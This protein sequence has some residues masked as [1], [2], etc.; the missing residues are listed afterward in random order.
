MDKAKYFVKCEQVTDRSITMRNVKG[1][2]R[3]RVRTVYLTGRVINGAFAKSFQ[4]KDYASAK[5]WCDKANAPW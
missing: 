4:F 3:S 5:A 2:A 1:N